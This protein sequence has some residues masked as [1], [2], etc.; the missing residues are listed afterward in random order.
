MDKLLTAR[1]IHCPQ[2]ILAVALCAWSCTALPVYHEDHYEGEQIHEHHHGLPPA[3]SYATISTTHVKVQHPAESQT[4]YATPYKVSVTLRQNASLR[5]FFF[6]FQGDNG[7]KVVTFQTCVRVPFITPK[8]NKFTWRIIKTEWKNLI[9]KR[10][11]VR[12]V[13][14]VVILCN[15]TTAFDFNPIRWQV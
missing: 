13:L 15:S 2:V 5:G 11:N 9:N 10:L 1:N 14:P 3:T 12:V 6:F 7:G 4:K 8:Y